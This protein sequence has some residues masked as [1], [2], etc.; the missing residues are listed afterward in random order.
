MKRLIT[1]VLLI[2]GISLF[3]GGIAANAS[4]VQTKN[5]VFIGAD[6]ISDGTL[7]AAGQTVTMAGTVHGDFFCAGQ[8]VDVVGTV[9]GDI[10]CAAQQLNIKGKVGGNVRLAGQQVTIASDVHGSATVFGQTVNFEQQSKIGGDLTL[11]AQAATLSGIIGR[12]IAGSAQSVRISGT[13]GRDIRL[14]VDKL[15]LSSTAKIN[16]DLTYT[17]NTDATV[18]QGSVITGAAVR[19]QPTQESKPAAQN[20]FLAALVAELYWFIALLLMGVAVMLFKPRLLA[21]TAERIRVEPGAVVGWG[22]LGVLAPPLVILLL[23]ITLVGLPLALLVGVVWAAMLLLSVMLTGHAVGRLLLD[24]IK[25]KANEG[26]QQFLGLMLGLLVLLALSLIPF[27]GPAAKVLAI[28]FGV[29]SLLSMAKRG[30]TKVKALSTKG[31]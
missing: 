21:R 12:D 16:G 26:W 8:T 4:S 19:N 25:L 11:G 5:N 22:L 31:E 28:V 24:L 20:S 29:G 9:D 18:E 15:A 30:S 1:L 14:E 23:M 17:S 3:S 7:Y 10:I 13:V 2:L 6:Q 27:V